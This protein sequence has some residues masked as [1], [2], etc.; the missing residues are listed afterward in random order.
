MSLIFY[1]VVLSFPGNGYG[2]FSF[3]FYTNDNSNISTD[4]NTNTIT[5][6]NLT[7]TQLSQTINVCCRRIVIIKLPIR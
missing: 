4:N 2:A 3:N 5:T 7:T 6:S 1:L